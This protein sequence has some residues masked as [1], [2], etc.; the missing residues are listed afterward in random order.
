[1]IEDAASV[2]PGS[3]TLVGYSMGG[4][5]A[6]HMALA[7]PKRVARLVLIGASPGVADPAERAA[8]RE[9]DERL[10]DE[11]EGLPLEE[12][13][14][15]WASNPVLAGQPAWVRE[16]RLRNTP[17]GLAR[18]LR[19]LGTG[20]LPP[21]WERLG[22]LRMPVVLVVGERDRKFRTIA[23]AMS[24]GIGDVEVVVV[25]DVGHAVHLEAPPAVADLI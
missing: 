1:V 4:R 17:S 16:D 20:A 10:A 23:D 9:A 22:E 7:M 3:F 25:P 14:R 24:A 21:L 12:F 15:R 18:A 11:I 6:L 8:R 13:A 5:I 2:R 19:G